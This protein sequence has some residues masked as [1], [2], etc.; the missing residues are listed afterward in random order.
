M[1]MGVSPGFKSASLG[2]D[3]V[4]LSTSRV[5]MRALLDQSLSPPLSRTTLTLTSSGPET[6]GAK[7]KEIIECEPP[8]TNG[9]LEFPINSH[10]RS[11]I[12]SRV[13]ETPTAS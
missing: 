12:I 1:A 5:L 13:P 8:R 11:V 3:N 9:V 4:V 10:P 2:P 6:L 7:G